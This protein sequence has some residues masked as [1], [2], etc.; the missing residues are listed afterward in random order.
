MARIIGAVT[1]IIKE[2]ALVIRTAALIIEGEL[3]KLKVRAL[4]ES[5]HRGQRSDNPLEMR[6][7]RPFVVC[8][9]RHRMR[10]AGRSPWTCWGRWSK[11]MEIARAR[12]HDKYIPSSR[13][14]LAL[15][16]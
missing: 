13:Q 16:I 5:P 3:E 12:F 4:D 10:Q 2:I 6:R 11:A 15:V 9:D 14:R 8:N 1:S 7:A